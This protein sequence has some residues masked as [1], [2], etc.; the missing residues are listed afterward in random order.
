MSTQVCEQQ[1]KARDLINVFRAITAATTPEAEDALEPMS[2]GKVSS[3]TVRALG[4]HGARLPQYARP[5]VGCPLA[6]RGQEFWECK[7]TLV[8]YESYLLRAL[9]YDMEITLPH[10]YRH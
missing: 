5:E 8:E 7:D 10:R 2:I 4:R 6:A 9:H 1:R 3:A